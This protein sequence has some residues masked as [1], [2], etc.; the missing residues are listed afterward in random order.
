MAS[1]TRKK[2]MFVFFIFLSLFYV[3]SFS[4]STSLFYPQYAFF[5]GNDSSQFLT[6]GK[7]WLFGKIPY[8]D[9][10]DHKGPFIFLVN[11]LGF[12]LTNGKS[13]FGVALFQIIFMFFTLSALYSISQLVQKGT[14]FGIIT[15]CLS[16]ILMRNNY[17]SGNTVEEYCIPFLC[18]SAFFLLKYLYRQESIHHYRCSFFYGITLGICFLTRITN[19]MP[20]CGLIFIVLVTLIRRKD[21]LGILKNLL[22]MTTGFLVICAP[23]I[24]YFMINNSLEDMIFATFSYNVTYA[25]TMKSWLFVGDAIRFPKALIQF[26]L[27]IIMFP[28]AFLASINKRKDLAL[29]YLITFIV[30]AFFFCQGALFVQYAL[31]CACHVPMFL[32]ELFLYK[33][34][35]QNNVLY[36]IIFCLF[37]LA[38]VTSIGIS[39]YVLSLRFSEYDAPSP[40]WSYL[41]EDIP[42][43]EKDSIVI[44]GDNEF[45][46]TYLAYD[47]LPCYK[48][49]IIQDWHGA[50][51]EYVKN[52]IQ[53]TFRSL[54]AKW[55]LTDP[56]CNLIKDILQDYYYVYDEVGDYKLYRLK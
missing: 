43:S 10:F 52:D 55:I 14:K 31:V 46:G 4:F 22:S 34:S 41:I 28:S 42:E 36:K 33:A 49:H 18:W 45:K 54:D 53:A 13:H 5:H 51:S 40:E 16:L 35:H 56:N 20:L 7:A 50:F 9:M 29:A 32:N 21:Y 3:L 1:Y 37:S 19:F 39:I 23:F 6:I 27:S 2:N 44:Y 25:N 48:Y 38:I 24:L 12:A 15:V 47:I 30:E 26:F 8:R 11:M 17:S